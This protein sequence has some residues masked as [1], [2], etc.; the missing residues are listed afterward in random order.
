MAAAPEQVTQEKVGAAAPTAQMGAPFGLS[1]SFPENIV[2]RMVDATSLHDYEFSLF[3]STGF[4]SA[5][6]GFGVEY[7][8]EPDPREQQ[9]FGIVSLIFAALT[10]AFFIWGM[11]KR[12]RMT[13]RSRQFRM[14][15]AMV[16]DVTTPNAPIAFQ[17]TPSAEEPHSQ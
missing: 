13:V 6:V 8:R 15:A 5:F 7:L 2:I 14:K 16:E 11:F 10:V 1:I 4:L 3:I 17:V 12:R 9:L